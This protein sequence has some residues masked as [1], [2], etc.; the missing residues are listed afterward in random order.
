[1]VQFAEEPERAGCDNLIYNT[2][3]QNL[4]FAEEPEKAGCDSSYMAK[5]NPKIINMF[6]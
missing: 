4:T 5:Q 1:L 6:L 2:S 3:C